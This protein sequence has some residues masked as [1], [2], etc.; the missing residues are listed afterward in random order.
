MNVTAHHVIGIERAAALQTTNEH[1]R[2]LRIV[3][4]LAG[5]QIPRATVGEIA[6]PVRVTLGDLLRRLKLHETAQRIADELAKQAPA[7]AVAQQRGING[8][9]DGQDRES[10][11]RAQEAQV[12]IN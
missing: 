8:S 12:L 2:H 9:H 7:G 3:R 6:H 4:R 10:G 5:D 1:H 11:R